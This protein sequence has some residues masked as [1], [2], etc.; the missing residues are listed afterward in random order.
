MRMSYK[1]KLCVT[2]IDGCDALEVEIDV[3]NAHSFSEAL[4]KAERNLS[5]KQSIIKVIGII[6]L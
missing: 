6:K 3:Q 5:Y 4:I 1:V 2:D